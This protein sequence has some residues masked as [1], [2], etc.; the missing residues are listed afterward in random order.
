M[1]PVGVMMVDGV[2]R[3]I[4]LRVVPLRVRHHLATKDHHL[5]FTGMPVPRS[6]RARARA[7]FVCVCSRRWTF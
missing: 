4:G 7:V 5:T 1:V 3:P 2:L 6:P